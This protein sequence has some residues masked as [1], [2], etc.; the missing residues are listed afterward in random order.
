[1]PLLHD[2]ADVWGVVNPLTLADFDRYWENMGSRSSPLYDF[3]NAKYVIAK[4][5]VTLD[6][7]KFTPVF[8]GDPVLNVYLNRNSLPRAFVVHQATLVSDQGAAFAAIHAPG[9]DPGRSVVL[10][11]GRDLNPA[12]ADHSGRVDVTRYALNH[13]DLAADM[14]A[15][16]YV[17]LSEVFYPGW[18][19]RVDGRVTSIYRA[20]YAFR[21][22]YVEQG[23]HQVTLTFRPT[24]FYL[25][26][27]LSLVV[28]AGM[29]I[30]SILGIARRK[31][32]SARPSE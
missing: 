19:A 4:K 21:A 31:G 26:A 14:P 30:L 15:D 6:W 7:N 9:F 29:I 28:L 24:S 22:I 32:V 16:G 27:A 20:N 18:E 1:L 11:A 17:V 10:E 8:D 5:D 12:T 13:I 3:L 25:G 23:K 2:I